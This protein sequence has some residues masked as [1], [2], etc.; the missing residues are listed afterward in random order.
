MTGWRAR[1][2]AGRV[3]LRRAA[4]G[5]GPGLA[6]AVALHAVS[7]CALPGPPSCGPLNL[8]ARGGPHILPATYIGVP[9]AE[10][11]SRTLAFD[12]FVHGDDVARPTAVIL[13]GGNGETTVGER[14]AFVGQ[15]A[16]ALADAGY[17]V[18]LPDY[19]ASSARAAQDDLVDLFQTLRCHASTLR[20]DLQRVAL[21]GE[22]SGGDAALRLTAYLGALRRGRTAQWPAPPLATVVLAATYDDVPAP[23]AA[24]TLLVHGTSDS[25]VP[26]AR[27]HAVCATAADGATCDVIEVAGA[28]HRVENWWP[29]QWG[30]KAQV[31]D[32]LAARLGTPPPAAWPDDPNLHKRVVFDDAHGLS[33]DAWIPEGGGPFPAVVIAHGGGWEAGDR[34]TYVTPLFAPLAARG[35]AWFSI[36]YRLTPEVTVAEQV[37]DVERA[38]AFVRREASSFRVDPARLV[39]AGESA[40]GHLVAHL[41]TRGID[42]AGVVSFYGVYDLASMAGDPASPRSLA[43]RLFGFTALDA[44]ARQTLRAYSPVANASAAMPPVLLVTGTADGLWPQAQAFDAALAAAGARYDS[45][46]LPDAPHGME[47]WNADPRWRDWA[48]RVADWILR[49]TAEASDASG[50]AARHPRESSRP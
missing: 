31:V 1:C 39:L 9:Y 41:A 29:S 30:Y 2:A 45:I 3:R 49:V 11:G 4:R 15:V 26:P 8:P 27:A 32:W 47:R 44:Q 14:T 17:Q 22:H 34:V 50:D 20:V 28:S 18:V 16:E 13:R 23:I 33:L 35:I 7:G 40:S 12:L 37:A 25:E 36:D 5:A 19:R 43:R 42:A 38:M 6:A 48:A 10:R 46:V 24:P 21:V